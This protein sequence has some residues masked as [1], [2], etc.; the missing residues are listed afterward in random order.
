MRNRNNGATFPHLV[1]RVM[2]ENNIMWTE[3]YEVNSNEELEE[4]YSTKR[5]EERVI[6]LI[7]VKDDMAL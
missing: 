4:L 6:E 7:S 1:L 5:T 3:T 2:E